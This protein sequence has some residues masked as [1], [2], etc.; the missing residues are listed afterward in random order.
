MLKFFIFIFS[1][2]KFVQNVS[3]ILCPSYT[4]PDLNGLSKVFIDI[5]T[6]SDRE[7]NYAIQ[8]NYFTS[9]ILK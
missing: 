2:S 8:V 1:R 5:Y 7:I 3:R 6:S 4:E 9:F